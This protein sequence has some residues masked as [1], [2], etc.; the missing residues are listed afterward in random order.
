MRKMNPHE[1]GSLWHQAKGAFQEDPRN[2]SLPC[3]LL[4]SSTTYKG[5]STK[6][7]AQPRRVAPSLGPFN[8]DIRRRRGKVFVAGHRGPHRSQDGGGGYAS[9]EMRAMV[10]TEATASS[11][12]NH[13]FSLLPWRRRR[14]LKHPFSSSCVP[15]SVHRSK[16]SLVEGA[17]RSLCQISGLFLDS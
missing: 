4:G 2:V 7:P 11:A 17:S 6:S 16:Q 3:R 12:I 8:R 14:R 13:L 15:G 10:S 5:S 1:V 9:G